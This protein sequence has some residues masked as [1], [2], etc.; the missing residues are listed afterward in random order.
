MGWH[1]STSPSV[2]VWV[3]K[4]I[5]GFFY[6][7]GTTCIGL[8]HNSNFA[9]GVV[10]E[11]FNGR[12]L[13]AHMAIA[14]R[15]TPAYLAAIFDY[16]FNV[17]NVNKVILPVASTNLRCIRFVCHLGFREEARIRDADPKGHILL[18]TM[19]KSRCRFLRE[20]YNGKIRTSA[21]AST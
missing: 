3:A 12:S 11:Q 10:Y 8:V 18:F 14:E 16:P 2:G 19:A 15:M 17:C 4:Q 21:P 20:R 9:A 5:D 6:T 1:I 13:V 7:P